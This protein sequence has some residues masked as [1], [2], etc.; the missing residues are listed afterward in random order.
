[1]P[2]SL[3]PEQQAWIEA[4]VNRGEF[5]SIDD[6]ARQLIDERIAE[7]MAAERDD[8]AWAKPYIDEA[9]AE[10]SRGKVMTRD[11]HETRMAALLASFRG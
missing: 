5:P 11:E 4:H 1:M 9:R 6:A 7:R 3:T 2:V 8:V 10:V